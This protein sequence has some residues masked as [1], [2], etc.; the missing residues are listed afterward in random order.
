M[1]NTAK[2]LSAEAYMLS[3]L[4][5]IELVDNILAS[6]DKPDNEID[7]L[8]VKEAE[9]RLSAWRSGEIEAV[10]LDQVLAKYR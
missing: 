3:P 8:W 5:R 1:A 9:D 4:E 10:D 2:Q 6:L 7:T